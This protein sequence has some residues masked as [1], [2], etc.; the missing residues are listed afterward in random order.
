MYYWIGY[1]FWSWR[2]GLMWKLFC[3]SRRTKLLDHT[4]SGTSGVFP[5]CGLWVISHC[6]ASSA[7]EARRWVGLDFR[8][9][10]CSRPDHKFK[11][12]AEWSLG[13]GSLTYSL[14][15]QVLRTKTRSQPTGSIPM[16]CLPCSWV[17]TTSMASGCSAE[18]SHI[19][20]PVSPEI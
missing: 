10:G 17:Y 2:N 9:N 13:Q 14:R 1:I 8:V 3:G 7:Q 20:Y 15:G 18:Q 12:T 4:E 16:P 19:R 6:G 11:H 5:I